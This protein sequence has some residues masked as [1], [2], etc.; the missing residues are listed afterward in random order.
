MPTFVDPKARVE[1]PLDEHNRVWVKARMDLRT[2]TAVENDLMSIRVNS[3]QMK[4]AQNG[5][6]PSLD[7]VFSL[8]AQKMILLKHNIV[9]WAGPMFEDNGQVV[10]CTPENIERLDP[11]DGGWWIDLV[12]DRIGELNEK[13]TAAV[14]PGEATADP[15]EPAAATSLK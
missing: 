12:A 11:V 7:I 6:L 14:T 1:I 8:T 15:N 2:Q 5:R 13:K 4:A 9:R 3:D 10:P